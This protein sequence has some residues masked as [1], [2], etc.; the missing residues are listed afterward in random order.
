ML[1]KYLYRLIFIIIIFSSL[2]G[3][4]KQLNLLLN[5][6]QQINNLGQKISA[7]VNRNDILKKSLNP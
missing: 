6:Q 7:L 1:K 4:Y 2:L 5:A 3:I